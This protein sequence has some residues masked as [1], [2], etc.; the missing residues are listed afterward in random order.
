MVIPRLLL[1]LC[2]TLVQPHL[3]AQINSST[4]V[5]TSLVNYEIRRAAVFCDSDNYDSVYVWVSKAL[6]HAAQINYR[7][8]ITQAEITLAKYY[9]TKSRF[10]KSLSLLL[11][12][13]EKL[14]AKKDFGRMGECEIQIGLFYYAQKNMTMR[15]HI[16]PKA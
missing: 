2:I 5:D 10:D 12:A 13:H 8:G 3:S 16:F 6:T 14:E 11:S 4:F 9:I 15:I 7:E 1:I